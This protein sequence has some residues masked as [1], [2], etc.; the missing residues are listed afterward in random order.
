MVGHICGKS[1][2]GARDD[3]VVRPIP[4]IFTFHEQN[5]D[6]LDL[7]ARL[8]IGFPERCLDRRLV[9]V[10]STAWQAPSV[11]IVTPGRPVLKQNG[12]VLNEQESSGAI[13]PP[14]TSAASAPNPAIAI[15]THAIK[16]PPQACATPP[17]D[18]R[19]LRDARG[20]DN[21][22]RVH[23]KI[24]SVLLLIPILT[25]CMDSTNAGAAAPL[26]LSS[27]VPTISRVE[28]PLLI[29]ENIPTAAATE[30]FEY[31]RLF[32]LALETG[33]TQDLVQLVAKD[34]PCLNPVN[35]II[36]IY[37]DGVL[38]G[39]RYRITRLTLISHERS[40]ATIQVESKRGVATQVTAST[41]A[42]R[43]FVEHQNITNFILKNIDESWLI[44][45]SEDPR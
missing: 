23:L 43:Q 25:S 36:A 13:Q 16:Y 34:C 15:A 27:T 17:R 21:F 38:L 20:A 5:V 44:V 33:R 39:A 30:I 42:R 11:S 29:P 10:S 26:A 32:N 37:H 9:G 4:V 3:R 12:T 41:G 40:W 28:S 6:Q 2:S 35:A 7:N 1:N 14:V 24:M 8:F 45:S 31:F 22:E 19:Q 18:K